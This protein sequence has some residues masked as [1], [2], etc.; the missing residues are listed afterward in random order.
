MDVIDDFEQRLK[1]QIA[2]VELIAE[3]NITPDEVEQLRQCVTGFLTTRGAHSATQQLEQRYPAVLVMFLVTQGMYGYQDGDYWSSVSS[4]TQ[5][6][7]NTANRWGRVFEDTLRAWQKPLFPHLGGRRYVDRILLHG[8]IPDYCLPDFFEH[9]LRPALLRPDLMLLDTD[10]LITDWLT[11]SSVRFTSDKPVL[12]FLEYGGALANNFVARCLDMA[13]QYKDTGML[14][15][16]VEAGLP[17]RVIAKYAEWVHQREHVAAQREVQSRLQKPQLWF[18]PDGDGILLDLPAQRFPVEAHTITVAWQITAGEHTECH[19]GYVWRHGTY[20]ETEALRIPIDVVA[21]DYGISLYLD[22]TL[23]RHWHFPGVCTTVPVLA[24]DAQ[25]GLH[26][27][28]QGVLPNQELWLVYPASLS[29]TAEH[30]LLRGHLDY[31]P[32]AWHS[33]VASCWSL[34]QAHTLHIGCQ[35]IAIEPD[36]ATLRPQLIGGQLCQQL[37]ST[38]RLTAYL[39]GPPDIRIPFLGHREQELGRWRIHIRD[40]H[41]TMLTSTLLSEVDFALTSDAG[42]VVVNLRALGLTHTTF[43]VFTIMMRGPLGRDATF[44]IALIP[45]LVM[46]GYEQIRLPDKDGHY[47]DVEL[48][49]ETSDDV[50]VRSEDSTIEPVLLDRGTTAMIIP[51]EYTQVSLHLHRDSFSIP[52]TLALPIL[53]WSISDDQGNG[54]TG[55]GFRNYPLVWLQQTHSPRLTVSAIPSLE[56]SQKLSGWVQVYYHSESTPQRLQ[57]RGGSKQHWMQFYLAEAADSIRNSAA[58]SALYELVLEHLSGATQS[59]NLPLLRITKQ[60][61]VDYLACQGMYQ[62]QQCLLL[63]RWR[64]AQQLNHRCLRLW[65]QWRPWAAPIE[66]FI[67]DDAEREHRWV[68]AAHEVPP[69]AYRAELTVRDPWS[70]SAPQRPFGSGA[71]IADLMLGRRPEQ[72]SYLYQLPETIAGILEHSLA[73]T[74]QE[75][76]CNLLHTLPAQAS[77]EE[78]IVLLAALLELYQRSCSVEQIPVTGWEP[79]GIFQRFYNPVR[80]LQSLIHYVGGI[81]AHGQILLEDT[82]QH[83]SSELGALFFRGIREHALAAHDLQRTLGIQEPVR[84][85][86]LITQLASVGIQVRFSDEKEEQQPDRSVL[87]ELSTHVSELV[88][89]DGIRMYL[90]EIGQFSLLRADQ[91]QELGRC[92]ADGIAAQKELSFTTHDAHRRTLLRRIELGNAAREALIN[93]NLRLVVNVAKKYLYRMPLEDLIQEGNIGLL[94]AVEKFDVSLGHKFS[95]YATWWIRQAITRGIA[96]KERLIRLPVHMIETMN[97]IRRKRNHLCVSLGR[98]PTNTELAAACDIPIEK[99]CRV[100]S[101]SHDIIS[102]ETPVDDDQSSTLGDFLEAPDNM[103]IDERFEQ[104]E[105]A[106]HTAVLLNHLSERERE[107]IQ[108]RFGFEDGERHTLEEIGQYYGVTRERIRQIEAKALKSLSRPKYKRFLQGDVPRMSELVEEV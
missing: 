79:L 103:S 69:G 19:E 73:C 21:E 96:D 67:P 57:A 18:D 94:K 41:G 48:W 72:L 87:D 92:I 83:L 76:Q 63:L 42:S 36:V 37:I 85:H 12:R 3:I 91:E 50:T 28:C 4:L 86:P 80:L 34:Q 5:I 97:R 25:T 88:L 39:G 105:L 35:A 30:G 77:N 40:Q 89:T 99:F 29:V 8:G 108:M 22:R 47:S 106:Q 24:F 59:L 9:M 52:I 2:H 20:W 23:K 11:N 75:Q 26:I 78:L 74:Q 49:L 95:T 81:D 15:H 43:G 60:L 31:L 70:S 71:H 61:E 16:A 17:E 93:A 14:P 65:S 33:Y 68:L 32:G 101:V 102:L 84:R 104:H 44:F 53:R 56:R 82:L 7:T 55:S 100:L 46:S 66:L 27:P 90:R 64:G 1:E 38:T 6:D 45:S 13:R 62:D 58:P 107:V 10:D 98:E 54:L 51:G